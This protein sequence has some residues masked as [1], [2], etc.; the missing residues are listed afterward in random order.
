MNNSGNDKN[1]KN[2]KF[3]NFFKKFISLTLFL[4]I[5]LGTVGFQGSLSN[6][7]ADTFSS[8]SNGLPSSGGGGGSR[9]KYYTYIGRSYSS[10]FRWHGGKGGSSPITKSMP[11]EISTVKY[12]G[13]EAS[14][15]IPANSSKYAYVEKNSK[16]LNSWF[17][18][19]WSWWLKYTTNKEPGAYVIGK[20]W[21]GAYYNNI[22]NATG[23][24]D[25]KGR[26]TD[27]DFI[28][29]LTKDGY[30]Y[31][32]YYELY[33]GHGKYLDA[34]CVKEEEKP[35]NHSET[36][37]KKVIEKVIYEFGDG[38]KET[39]LD[40]SGKTAKELWD[41]GKT[42]WSYEGDSYRSIDYKH[43]IK[44]TVRT[45]TQKT[46]WKTLGG[47]EVNGSKNVTYTKNGTKTM[48]K[49]ITY[50]VQ[51]PEIKTTIYTPFDLNRNGVAK[52]KDIKA[53]YPD[54]NESNAK[55]LNM[56]VNNYQNIMD[57]TALQTLD[58]NTST[59]FN[60]TFNNDQFGIPKASEGGIDI[61]KSV[62][63]SNL[64]LPE[65][66]YSTNMIFGNNYWENSPKA[67][68][69]ILK[70]T[71]NGCTT[72]T[73]DPMNLEGCLSKNYYWG[74]SM[75][76]DLSA[77]TGTL[78]YNNDERIGGNPF[79]FSRDNDFRG[80]DFIFKTTKT[81]DYN[82]K[83]NGRNWWEVQYEQ[84]IFYTFEIWYEGNITTTDITNPTEVSSNQY[85][86][87][88]SKDVYQPVMK[89]L[90]EAKTVAGNIG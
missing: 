10:G 45:I 44:V 28:R 35:Q 83:S 72:T 56:S 84:G 17:F 38:T 88:A 43:V 34:V 77:D 62:P 3:K 87:L 71:G 76:S 65:G 80:G 89:G 47:K 55:K 21:D 66:C 58:T 53:T 64:K 46:T 32:G 78:T 20:A 82:L 85:T 5:A 11:S 25:T 75:S 74:G 29:E 67:V 18:C 23:I 40:D 12:L 36:K 51:K 16:S 24:N 27:A 73:M 63:F 48:K 31:N 61:D 69:G 2:H 79:T 86:A 39:D 8:T 33:Q 7:Y 14:I 19:R 57:G 26:F 4:M 22:W 30:S 81:G 1:N 15:T 6:V 42:E 54:Y 49:T 37:T 59:K 52:T 70:A 60:I 9:N 90:F 13:S 41:N 68:T 50:K